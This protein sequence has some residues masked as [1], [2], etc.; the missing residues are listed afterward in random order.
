MKKRRVCASV[1]KTNREQSRHVKGRTESLS[2]PAYLGGMLDI[3]TVKH[4]LAR[5]E[6]LALASTVVEL[7]VTQVVNGV[8]GVHALLPD[9]AIF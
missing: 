6:A 2:H 8:R 3:L 1:A 7:R 4:D 5:H 9:D